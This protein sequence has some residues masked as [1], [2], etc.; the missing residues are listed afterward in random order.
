MVVEQ[1]Q[2]LEREELHSILASGILAKSPNLAK[3]LSYI[4]ERYWEGKSGQLKEYNLGV[5][6]LGRPPD[7]DPAA[8]AIVRV[9]VHRLREKLKKFYE[10]GGANHRIAIFL[11][12]GRYVPQFVSLRKRFKKRAQ[13]DSRRREMPQPL[14]CRCQFRNRSWSLRPQL[15][16]R[17]E[18]RLIESSSESP[19]FAF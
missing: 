18:I 11:P 6:A 3:L 8:S 12:P 7:F 14:V 17:R 5:D 19:S 15:W 10:N 2:D 13:V 4:C 1:Q 9:E 16:L